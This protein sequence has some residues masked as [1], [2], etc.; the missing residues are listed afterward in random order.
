MPAA[1]GLW[2]T[3]SD[4]VRL[5]VGWASLL[6]DAVAAEALDRGIGW[7][8]NRPKGIYGHRGAGPGA[9]ASLAVGLDGGEVV[10]ACTN[11]RPIGQ[12]GPG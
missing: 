7:M 6:P 10:A 2:T 8:V 4:L 3:P 1:G 9:G 11:R 12:V 5:G